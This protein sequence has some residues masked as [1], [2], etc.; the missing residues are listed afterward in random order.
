[1]K[2]MV[3]AKNRAK[4]NGFGTGPRISSF[5]SISIEVHSL[6]AQVSSKVYS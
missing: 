4:S 1:M 5:R 2:V 6:L 3:A